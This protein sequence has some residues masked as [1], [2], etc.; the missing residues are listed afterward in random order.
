MRTESN[1]QFDFL[2][3]GSDHN[4]LKRVLGHLSHTLERDALVQQ[5]THDL[6]EA[7]QVDRVVLYYFYSQWKGQVT[8]ESLSSPDYSI[9]GSTG[10]DGCFNDEYAALYIAGRVR[11]IANVEQEPIADCHR[12]FLRQ[13]GVQANLVVPIL[14]A[15][16]LWGLLTAHHCQSPREWTAA[17]IDRMSA[18][19]QTLATAPAVLMG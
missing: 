5:T 17:D 4:S 3:Q 7:L 10:P 11:A 1:P 16:G 18:G 9:Y 2:P 15:K 13:I 14:T 12:E 19:A 8:F 6:R